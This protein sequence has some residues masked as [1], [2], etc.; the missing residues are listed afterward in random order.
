MRQWTKM[1]TAMG[2]MVVISMLVS[3]AAIAQPS[4]NPSMH[5]GSKLIGADV[6]NPQGQDLGDIKDVIIDGQNG[7]VAYVVVAFGG[8]MGL[9]D[10]YFAVPFE[11]LRTEAGQRP[12]DREKYL[13]NVDKERMKNAPGF[14][15]NNWPN[16]ADRTW[17]SQV[18]KYYELKPYWER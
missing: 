4:M 14:D 2:V 9:G 8:L 11:A 18:Y 3:A 5:R 16:M 15:Q 17:G 1:S 6:E 13:L 12:G 10:K 7:R